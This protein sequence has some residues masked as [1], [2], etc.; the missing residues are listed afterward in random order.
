MRALPTLFFPFILYLCVRVWWQWHCILLRFCFA[1]AAFAAPNEHLHSRG[2]HCFMMLFP[3]PNTI[4]KCAKHNEKISLL[5]ENKSVVF[6]LSENLSNWPRNF[7]SFVSLLAFIL[8][9]VMRQMLPKDLVHIDSF[10][11]F[12]SPN[13]FCG[14]AS[15]MRRAKKLCLSFF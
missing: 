15:N 6:F 11:R 2:G 8:C 14:P 1:I 10:M 4:E 7:V 13:P 12:S 5:R 3:L 9:D